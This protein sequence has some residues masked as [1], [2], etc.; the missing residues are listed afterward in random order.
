M[1][2]IKRT[3]YDLERMEKVVKKIFFVAMP[4]TASVLLVGL[5]KTIDSV[6]I[7]RGL[8]KFMSAEDAK[9]QYGILSGKIDTLVT[10]PMSFNM[11]LT[12]NLVPAISAANAKNCL[13][14]VERKIKFSVIFSTK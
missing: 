11:A 7:V 13:Q 10:L 2:K 9:L 8:K 6:T 1:Q 14:E 4:I 12:T 5:N 3:D